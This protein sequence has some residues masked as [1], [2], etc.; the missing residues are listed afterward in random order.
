MYTPSFLLLMIYV[1]RDVT[2]FA[3]GLRKLSIKVFAE[4]EIEQ[5][6]IATQ[7]LAKRKK[8][9]EEKEKAREVKRVKVEADKA[10]EVGGICLVVM[11]LSSIHTVLIHSLHGCGNGAFQAGREGRVDSWRDFAKGGD[12]KKKK[13][14]DKAIKMRGFKPPKLKTEQR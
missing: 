5:K 1:N 8:Q 6:V 11:R 12:K 4:K 10:W 3:A 7:E 2:Q 14:K 9:E 13:K